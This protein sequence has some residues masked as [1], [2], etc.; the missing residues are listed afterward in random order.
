MYHRAVFN[1]VN[2]KSVSKLLLG[3]FQ[4]T[5]SHLSSLSELAKRSLVYNEQ[6]GYV[7]KSPYGRVSI[8]DMTID[9]YVW[10]NLSKW[11]N[12]V[13]IECG[14]TGRKYTYAKLRDHCAALAI[15]LRTNLKLQK[16][17]IVGICLPNV[18]GNIANGLDAVHVFVFDK[19][20]KLVHFKV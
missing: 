12:H 16:G 5:Q 15:R 18:P 14:V 10:K 19:T 6:E 20:S 11:Q 4:S 3:R 8:P 7:M 2:V 1:S 9:Q 17:D 13:A